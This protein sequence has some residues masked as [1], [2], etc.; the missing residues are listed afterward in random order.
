MAMPSAEDLLQLLMIC[1]CCTW[2]AVDRR[3]WYGYC[4]PGSSAV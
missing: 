3:Q 2:S 4:L 1:L